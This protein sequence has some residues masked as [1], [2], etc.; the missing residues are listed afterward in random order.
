[1]QVRTEFA[2]VSDW[3]SKFPK[4]QFGINARLIYDRRDSAP[5]LYGLAS[6]PES[7]R[8]TEAAQLITAMLEIRIQRGTLFYQYRNLTGGQYEQIRGIT[9]PPAVQMYGLR[10]EFWN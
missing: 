9:M 8:V 7:V 4:G 6:D 1:M 3:R 5:F 10:W 2:L